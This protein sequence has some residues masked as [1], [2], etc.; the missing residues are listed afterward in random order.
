MSDEP[1]IVDE[2]QINLPDGY[3]EQ[4]YVYEFVE[5]FEY[6]HFHFGMGGRSYEVT[7]ASADAIEEHHDTSPKDGHIEY[8]RLWVFKRERC[9]L[10]IR[11][12]RRPTRTRD[13]NAP[14]VAEYMAALR[15]YMKGL[16]AYLARIKK[17]EAKRQRSA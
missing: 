10:R 15:E 8:A 17:D 13:P 7:I 5:R 9:A 14:T 6:S 16:P 2:F 11:G 1:T 3:R 4:A 12:I